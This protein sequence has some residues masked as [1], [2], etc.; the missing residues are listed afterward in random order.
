MDNNIENIIW[1]NIRLCY[2]IITPAVINNEK[3]SKIKE[4]EFNMRIGFIKGIGKY[5]EFD[6]IIKDNIYNLEDGYIQYTT[7]REH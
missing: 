6:D 2:E 5:I 3:I 7:L 1:E 4:D